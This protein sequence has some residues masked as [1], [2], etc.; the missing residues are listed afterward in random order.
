M[1]LF[2]VEAAGGVKPSPECEFAYLVRPA[3]GAHVKNMRYL[4][5]LFLIFL[6]VPVLAAPVL[7]ADVPPLWLSEWRETNFNKATVPLS[8]IRSGGPSKDGIPAIDSPVFRPAQDIKDI[9]AK[10]PV[11]AL[12]IAGDVRAYPLRVLMWHEIVNDTVG[13]L[14]VVVSYCPL[15]NASIVFDRR[16]NGQVL[17]FGTTGK[18]RHSDLVMYDRQTESWWQHFTG[19]AIVGDFAGTALKLVPSR[20]LAF[21]RFRDAFPTAQVLVSNNPAGRR[22]GDNP[23][24]GYDSRAVPYGLFQGELP[25]DIAAMARVIVVDG[26]AWSLALLRARKEINENGLVLSWAPGQSSAVDAEKI[27]LG[28]DVGNVRVT[29]NGQDVAHHISFA[30]VYRAFHPQ[31]RIRK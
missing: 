26:E 7:A 2:V 9:G 19:D 31:G 1:A 12:E 16:V 22:Y 6:T 23:Y 28:R 11:V 5:A 30:F 13:G 20:L 15:C 17:D 8:E 10:E 14:P 18:L 3:R 24:V 25:K 27:A 29:R 4:I 21:D